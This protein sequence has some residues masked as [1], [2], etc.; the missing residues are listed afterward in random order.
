MNEEVQPAEI[1]SPT[2]ME[3]QSRAE[4]DVA[5][6]TAKRFPRVIS[7][8]LQRAESLAT[9]TPQIAAG[10][11]YA[12]PIGGDKVKGPSARLA[13]IAAATY[14]NIRVQARIISESATE[15]VAQG[16][17]HDLETNVAQSTEVAV[18]ILTK[19]GKRYGPD[20]VA[21]C[22]AAACAKARRNATL[23]IIPRALLEPIIAKC[24]LVAA[25]DQKTL[26]A[27]RKDLLDWFE[28]HGAKRS[29]IFEWLEVKTEEDID[30]EK[31][32][33]LIAARNQAKDDGVAVS[34]M[35]AKEAGEKSGRFAQ[36]KPPTTGNGATVPTPTHATC[37]ELAKHCNDTDI[38]AVMDTFQV[39]TIA[40]I[41]ETDLVAFHAALKA[42]KPKA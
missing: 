30:L 25:G 18:S 27:R 29:A 41:K 38:L 36:D 9:A 4:Y 3:S 37:V 39:H 17:A 28:S 13:E 33:D 42:L 24:R 26:P 14:G 2:V 34:V 35:F 22:R 31:M 23:L 16:V 32:A 10:M 19:A 20:Q 12:R 6:T 21:T 7:A 40:S 15:V 11:E 8:F 5:I 1:I